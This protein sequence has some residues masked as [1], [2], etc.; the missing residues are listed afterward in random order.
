MDKQKAKKRI[1]ELREIIEY[2]NKRY[3]D[4]DSNEI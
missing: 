4:N 3:Y 2:H 1:E